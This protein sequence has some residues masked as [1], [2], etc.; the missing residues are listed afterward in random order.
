MTPKKGADTATVKCLPVRAET[1]QMRLHQTTHGV[2]AITEGRMPLVNYL[3]EPV[4]VLRKLGR[5]LT[6]G[7]PVVITLSKRCVPPVSHPRSCNSMEPP[8]VLGT[9]WGQEGGLIIT[10]RPR[11]AAMPRYYSEDEALADAVG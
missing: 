4:E 3:R 2:R 11:R 9:R 10:E 1:M 5:V 6:M 8:H 7:S